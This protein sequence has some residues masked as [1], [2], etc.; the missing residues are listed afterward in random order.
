MVLFFYVFGAKY[1]A[2]KFNRIYISELGSESLRTMLYIVQAY[3]YLAPTEFIS[4]CGEKIC[5]RLNVSS[6]YHE[7]KAFKIA[8][9]L[10]WPSLTVLN[11]SLYQPQSNIS[12][13]VF[14]LAR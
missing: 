4:N 3:L 11:L 14:G 1:M 2:V 5:T 7:N 12:G 6:I 8:R 10:V 13:S 9:H